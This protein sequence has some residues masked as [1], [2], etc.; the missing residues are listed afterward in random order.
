MALAADGTFW[1]LPG[2]VSND[3]GYNGEPLLAPSRRMSKIEN[4]FGAKE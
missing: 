2:G 1:E 4:I 3:W